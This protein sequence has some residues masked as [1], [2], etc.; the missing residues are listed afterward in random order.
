ML[1]PEVTTELARAAERYDPDARSWRPE[2]PSGARHEGRLAVQ[3]G[4]RVLL[5]GAS[6]AS[7][8]ERARGWTEAEA[9]STC[10]TFD[11]NHSAWEDAGAMPPGLET[12]ARFGDGWAIGTTP[13]DSWMWRERAS[14]GERSGSGGRWASSPGYSGSATLAT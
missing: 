14:P 5:C 9:T 7:E 12:L 13:T 1:V 10:E 2:R 4:T 6:T 8:G 3:T 11:P